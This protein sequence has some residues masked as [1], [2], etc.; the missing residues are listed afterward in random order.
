MNIATIFKAQTEK[1][2]TKTK[3]K[4]TYSTEKNSLTHTCLNSNHQKIFWQFVGY[5]VLRILADTIYVLYHS[6]ITPGAKC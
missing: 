3:T 4:K 1:T 5:Y 6:R 2:K